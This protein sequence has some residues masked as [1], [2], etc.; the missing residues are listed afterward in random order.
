MKK[1]LV[2]LVLAA[3]TLSAGT[4][5]ADH[6]HGGRGEMN[7][8]DKLMK[9]AQMAIMNSEELGLSDEQ[10]MAL[11]D[12]KTSIKKDLIMKNAEI[13]VL[14]VDIKSLMW[15]DTLDTEKINAL[16]DK[17]YELKKAKAK[18]VVAGC[19]G[20]RK[21]LTEDQLSQMKTLCKKSMQ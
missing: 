13:D 6:W 1:L 20:I 17:K 14:K 16:I 11:K 19:D 15:A 3:F 4:V 7:M 21:T 5:Y 18:A 10:V 8:E 9:K 2:L 12:L